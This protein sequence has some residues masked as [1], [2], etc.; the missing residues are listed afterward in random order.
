MN[1]EIRKY[2]GLFLAVEAFKA[3]V[4]EES[5]IGTGKF[6]RRRARLSYT[7]RS[8]SIR[9]E[10]RS[11]SGLGSGITGKDFF[12]FSM[13]SGIFGAIQGAAVVGLVGAVVHLILF[14]PI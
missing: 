2:G 6:C 10:S 3:G 13:L 11:T 7:R 9:I 5:F 1:T 8:R 14:V 12:E 4:L